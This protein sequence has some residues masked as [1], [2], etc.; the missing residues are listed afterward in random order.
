MD[1]DNEK[2]GNMEMLLKAKNVN[3]GL[4]TAHDW[5]HTEF[6]LSQDGD[7]FIKV[8]FLN[9][10]V[11]TR[12]HICER[13]L[14]SIKENIE[15]I[16]SDPPDMIPDACDGEAWSFDAFD[17]TGKRIYRWKLNHIYGLESLE[18]IGEILDSYIPEYEKP[19]YTEE[20]IERYIKQNIGE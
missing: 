6:E 17:D 8:L 14:L 20:E 1:G 7:L 9:P 16:I 2:R 18:E 10:V 19:N 11:D 13:D 4:R 3:W 5:Q 15:K 12:V